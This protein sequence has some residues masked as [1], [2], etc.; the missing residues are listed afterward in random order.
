MQ[1]A[2]SDMLVRAHDDNLLED[3]SIKVSVQK[4]GLIF[5]FYI[6]ST[7]QSLPTWAITS[8]QISTA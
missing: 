1:G 2:L 5:L 6:N 4:W 7:T 3:Y 8:G